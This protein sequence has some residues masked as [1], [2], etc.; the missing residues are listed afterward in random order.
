MARIAEEFE[1]PLTVTPPRCYMCHDTKTVWQEGSGRVWIAGGEV[2]DDERAYPC[3]RCQPDAYA[4]MEELREHV[5]QVATEGMDVNNVELQ[6]IVCSRGW[7]VAHA[8][9]DAV[10]TEPVAL[11][12]GITARLIVTSPHAVCIEVETENG[13]LGEVDLDEIPTPPQCG[14]V[15][16][17]GR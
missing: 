9:V 11:G 13:P 12:L 8:T 2:C 14:S 17:N 10:Y 3:P 5:M 4:Y 15:D 6:E 7:T 16:E 1:G